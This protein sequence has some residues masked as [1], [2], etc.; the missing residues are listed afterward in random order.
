MPLILDSLHKEA[1]RPSRYTELWDVLIDQKVDNLGQPGWDYNLL[2]C[3]TCGGY[4]VST[5]VHTVGASASA[6]V[7]VNVSVSFLLLLLRSPLSLSLCCCISVLLH[8]LFTEQVVIL[9]GDIDFAASDA[10]EPSGQ[11]EMSVGSALYSW[12]TRGGVLVMTAPA[13][14]PLKNL[15]ILRLVLQS[16]DSETH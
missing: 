10:A 14:T 1:I 9:T 4:R 11:Y 8:H 16:F 12:V 7:S 6:S 13:A 15:L 5:P 2:G 3:S